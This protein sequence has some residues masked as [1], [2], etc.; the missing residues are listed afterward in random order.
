V[1]N[2]EC[3]HTSVIGTHANV[4]GM[5]KSVIGMHTSVIGMHTDVIGMHS[6][7]IGMHTSVLVTHTSVIEVGAVSKRVSQ[8]TKK[9]LNRELRDS[10]AQGVPVN[11]GQTVAY[12]AGQPSVAGANGV[13]QPPVAGANSGGRQ[14]QR[15]GSTAICN[16]YMAGLLKVPTAT[17][18]KE[19][20]SKPAKECRFAHKSLRETSYEEAKKSVL[21]MNDGDLRGRI[22]SLL[23]SSG[24]LFKP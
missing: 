2:S 23:A 8:R 14:G 10:L 3:S 6:S 21:A 1:D 15:R 5:H 24:S 18:G 4:F 22:S 20:C 7:V 13:E 11:T 16:R 19:G 9:R 12:V 17:G